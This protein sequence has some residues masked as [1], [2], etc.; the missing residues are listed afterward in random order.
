[1]PVRLR[2]LGVLLTAAVGLGLSACAAPPPVSTNGAAFDE[3]YGIPP[4]TVPA[5]LMRPDGLMI[6]GLLPEQPNAGS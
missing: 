2:R 5:Y 1:M 4:G 6:N 3:A